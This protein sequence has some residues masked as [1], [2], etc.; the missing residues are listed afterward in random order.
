MTNSTDNLIFYI[1]K[2][3]SLEETNILGD[4]SV[5]LRTFFRYDIKIY[6]DIM[7]NSTDNLIFYIKTK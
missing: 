2:P 6:A 3:N 4:Q 1:P 7:T 5:D